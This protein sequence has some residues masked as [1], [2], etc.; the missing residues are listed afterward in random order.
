MLDRRL[1]AVAGLLL[2]I[3][4]C[5]DDATVT[6][7]VPPT[8]T[9]SV[10]S[11][12]TTATTTT[13][14]ATTTTTTE[15][16]AT[17]TTVPFVDVLA[18]PEALAEMGSDWMEEVFIPYGSA[19]TDLG[20]S[21]GGEGGLLDLG[22]EYGA[23]GPDGTWWFL[24]V[25]KTRLARYAAD[26]A[27]LDALPI[28]VELLSQGVYAQFQLPRVLAGG[29]FVAFRLGQGST[30]MM[31]VTEAGFEEI[32]IPGYVVP[33]VDDGATLYGFDDQGAMV[34]V[35]PAAAVTFSVEWFMTQ[36]GSRYRITLVEGGLRIELPDAPQ[37]VDRILPM[38][39][40]ADSS[41]G[42][43]AGIQVATTADGRIHLLLT[44]AP[45]S[46]ESVQ[47]AGYATIL[48]D[49]SVTPVTPVRNPFTPSDPGSPGQLGAA[50]GTDLPWLMVVDVD[51]IRI[52]RPTG[53]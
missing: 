21:P 27:F 50:F 30:A 49:G 17:T 47:L 45:E 35:D 16:V 3:A 44:G 18:I 38:V 42:A 11:V 34:G 26:G 12:T 22:P 51:G 37:P 4:A 6:T 5:G 36:S 40:A 10:T 31:L 23:Q 20:T 53:G 28:P 43:F 13:V 7:T 9:A 46:D 1:A 14:A 29:E 25:A 39:Y 2:A 8:T 41:V 33:R 32:E 24:D 48:P 15:P 19:E 52:Y